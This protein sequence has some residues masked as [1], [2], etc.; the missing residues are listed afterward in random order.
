MNRN[1]YFRGLNKTRKQQRVPLFKFKL[2]ALAAPSLGPSSAA[3]H[4]T[5]LADW[6]WRFWSGA[7][8]LGR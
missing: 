7:A 6:D 1:V 8:V 3:E 4:V 2:V 5:R